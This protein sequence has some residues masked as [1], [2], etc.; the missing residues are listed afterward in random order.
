VSEPRRAPPI[1]A[2]VALELPPRLRAALAKTIAALA[3]SVPSIR[4]VDPGHTHL[5]LRFLGWTTRERLAVLEPRLAALAA[6]TPPLRPR[7][8][9]LGL[10]PPAGR[11]RVLWVGVALPPEGA[12]LQAGCEEAAVAAG[13]PPER[14]Q[15]QPHLTLGRWRDPMPRPKLPA[16]DLGVTAL[17]TLVLFRSKLR[18]SGAEYT[19]LA[20]Y[21]LGQALPQE[22]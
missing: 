6:A 7:V 2:F 13:F 3:P 11:A 12:A 10:F 20:T 9:G 8:A 5:T 4:W 14:R 15:Y 22:A 1:R 17:D 21:P 18:R 16:A 19:P